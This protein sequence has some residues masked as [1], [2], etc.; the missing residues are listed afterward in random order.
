VDLLLCNGTRDRARGG[1]DEARFTSGAL[2]VP[3]RKPG[4]TLSEIKQGFVCKGHRLDRDEF[5]N[6]G[7]LFG[8]AVTLRDKP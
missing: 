6:I 1:K 5:D 3:A 2:P 7:R 8:G 4:S